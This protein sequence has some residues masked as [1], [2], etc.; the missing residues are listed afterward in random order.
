MLR[1]Y[2]YKEHY[3]NDIAMQETE[4]RL[5]VHLDHCIELLRMNLMCMSDVSVLTYTWSDKKDIP[6]PDFDVTHRCRDFD[7]IAEWNRQ[8]SRITFETPEKPTHLL[9]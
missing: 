5:Q 2:V 9:A 7:K 3:K 6:N 4:E 1:K 8:S